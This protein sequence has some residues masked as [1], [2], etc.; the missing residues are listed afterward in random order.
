VKKIQNKWQLLP[1]YIA[2]SASCF[3]ASGCHNSDLEKQNTE[4][5]RQNEALQ[6]Q[7]IEEVA[8]QQQE[9]VEEAKR[10]REQELE[11]ERERQ[12]N[13]EITRHEE[14]VAQLQSQLDDLTAKRTDYERQVESYKNEHSDAINTI[15]MAES[16][17]KMMSNKKSSDG[18]Q[19]VGG[20]GVGAA[21]A[22]VLQHPE[23]YKSVSENLKTAE[24]NLKSYSNQ[25][26]ELKGEIEKEKSLISQIRN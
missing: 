12:R 26:E 10:L 1:L 19:F 2:L 4:L 16:G 21:I 23:E 11:Q 6:R 20:L 9:K 14:R 3:L 22:W 5:K 15:K 8:Q 24:N 13:S 7:K 17:S 25:I 18:E